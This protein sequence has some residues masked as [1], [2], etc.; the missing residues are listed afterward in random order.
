MSFGVPILSTRRD[1]VKTFALFAWWREEPWLDEFL[2]QAS[3]RALA[4]DCT[5]E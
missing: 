1:N 3:Y 2:G 4:G 5:S